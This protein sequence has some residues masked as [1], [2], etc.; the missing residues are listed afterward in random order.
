MDYSAIGGVIGV[1]IV[2]FIAIAYSTK[3]KRDD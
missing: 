3:G 1:F 2:I